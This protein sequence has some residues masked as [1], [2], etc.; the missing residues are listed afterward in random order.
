MFS[1][2]FAAPQLSGFSTEHLARE[3]ARR[4][5]GEPGS[6]FHDVFYHHGFHLLRKHFY[7][8]IPDDTDHLD[9]FWDKSSEMAGVNISD[10]LALEVMEQI[11]PK[12]LPEFRARFP[13]EGPLQPPGFYLINGGYMAVDAHVYYCLIRHFKPRKIIEIGNGN[14]T[15]LAI[16]ACGSNAEETGW[17][18]NL[19]SIDPYP[20]K[21]FKDGYPG[22][23]TLVVERVQDVPVSCFE[24][25]EAGDILFID[26]SHVIRSGN[27]VHYEFLEILPRLKPGVLVHVHDISLPR[28]YPKVY[29][30]NHLYW[31]EQYLLQ[32]FLA[33][34]NQFE[35][36]WPGNYM[37][38]NYPDRVRSIFPEFE[39]MRQDYP[40]SEPT[41]FWMR[42][43]KSLAQ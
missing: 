34:N 36:V 13:I 9:Q 22:L 4:I 6:P 27:D 8:P 26:S 41:A 2:F 42:V 35:V 15:L 17:R 21:L 5:E 28:P 10:A 12:Y 11:C 14:S 30:D 23:D 33:F 39:R 24:Q 32:A 19:T 43:K 20:W 7:L 38:V 18:A 40:Q 37:M 3:L 29:F 25:L 16:A 1:R 31:N